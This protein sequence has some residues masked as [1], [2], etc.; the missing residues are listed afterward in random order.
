MT[1]KQ[2]VEFFV[3]LV[4][5]FIGLL[6]FLGRIEQLGV[7]TKLIGGPGGTIYQIIIIILGLVIFFQSFR[8][9]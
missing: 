5:L 8:K 7:I 9:I 1:K 2:F 4:V 6:P 3:G